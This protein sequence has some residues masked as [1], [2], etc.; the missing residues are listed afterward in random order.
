MSVLVESYA[1]STNKKEE[2]AL[3]IEVLVEKN[4]QENGRT[5]RHLMKLRQGIQNDFKVA[6]DEWKSCKE[7]REELW[8]AEKVKHVRAC[9]V[10]ALQ[11]EIKRL[12]GTHEVE[13]N[14]LIE[15]AATRKRYIE[16][17]TEIDFHRKFNEYMYEANKRKDFL[18]EGRMKKWRNKIHQF[19]ISNA[20]K[21]KEVYEH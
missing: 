1:R 3:E 8:I 10:D 7:E 19:E 2:I 12:S 6:S 9:T 14:K 18:L 17:E 21:L 11:P 5:K 16:K 20:E 15:E 13:V 4:K